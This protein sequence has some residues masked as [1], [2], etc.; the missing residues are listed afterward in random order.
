MRKLVCASPWFES[1][2]RLVFEMATY[3]LALVFRYESL[4]DVWYGLHS[5]IRLLSVDSIIWNVCASWLGGKIIER[6]SD[7]VRLGN[8]SQKGKAE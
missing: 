3:T 6:E 4:I 1:E 8:K 5:D 7:F 2:K